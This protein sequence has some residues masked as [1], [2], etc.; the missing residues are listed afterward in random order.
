MIIGFAVVM[1]QIVDGGAGSIWALNFS[2]ITFEH[3]TTY[4]G[5][6][7]LSLGI[8][9][10]LL[11]ITS[12][13][14][15]KI[16]KAS[17]HRALI[18]PYIYVISQLMLIVL[19]TSLLMQQ[20]L[21]YGYNKLLSQLIIGLS[22]IVSV[23]IMSSL[24]Y[25]CI[26]SYRST[27]SKIAGI[28]AL[29]IVTLSVQLICAFL[30]AEA[31]LDKRPLYITSERNPWSSFFIT[32]LL[33]NLLSIYTVTKLISFLAIWIASIILT[34][35]YAQNTSKVKYWIIVSIP[36]IYLA[37]QYFL[38]LLNQMGALSSL[39][40]SQTS[41][42]PYLYN[43]VLSTANVGSGLLIG[44]SFF[45]LSRSLIYGHLKYFVVMC[46][47]GVMIIYSSSVSQ[48]LILTTF[49]AWSIVSTSF[50]LA[51]AFLTMIGL[52][53]ATLHIAG[54]VKLRK[55]LYKFRSQFELFTALSSEEGAAA[56]ERKIQKISKKIYNNLETEALYVVKPD[57]FEIKSYV[58][59]II[60]EMKRTGSIS[61]KPKLEDH[62][63]KSK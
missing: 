4:T 32:P 50:I 16:R 18:I 29:A 42:F 62:S 20:L 44:I 19:I 23:L 38:V 57:Q 54:D 13:M 3:I 28:Y 31:G 25:S 53:S 22:F 58:G 17:S 26:K 63:D 21:T 55:Y 41:I 43:F 39:M 60:A 15:F 24:A 2:H 14:V 12:R 56:V 11:F 49:P 34:R 47:I 27:K 10:F 52:G 7:I 9:V 51:A 40:I 5:I 45:I 6:V 35:S 59:V 33:V 46:G 61:D 1:I 30:Y 48:I 36:V 8:Q 37:F